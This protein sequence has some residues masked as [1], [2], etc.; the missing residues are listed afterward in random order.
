MANYDDVIEKNKR[1][2]T[3]AQVNA[4]VAASKEYNI[5]N[6]GN[7][8]G[9]LA[10]AREQYDTGYRGLQNMGLAGGVSAAPTSGEVPRLKTQ[11]QVP[12]EDYNRR[13]REVE[14]MR[15]NAL[16]GQMAESTRRARAAEAA[17]QEALR[18]AQLSAAAAKAMEERRISAGLRQTDME[19]TGRSG[20]TINSNPKRQRNVNMT[21][22]GTNGEREAEAAA[23]V[24]AAAE[25]TRVGAGLHQTA[26]EATGLSGSSLNIG[27]NRQ[28]NVNMTDTASNGEREA[29]SAARSRAAVEAAAETLGIATNKYN[30][31]YTRAQMEANAGKASEVPKF[32]VQSGSTIASDLKRAQNVGM[33][34]TASN[35]NNTGSSRRYATQGTTWSS[36]GG[37]VEGPSLKEVDDAIA[38]YE[39]AVKAYEDTAG[40]GAPSEASREP[41]NKANE[42]LNSLGFA[43]IYSAKRYRDSITNTN[44]PERSTEEPD[45]LVK[46]RREMEDAQAKY[47]SALAGTNTLQQQ[48]LGILRKR[49]DGK[50]VTEQDVQNV[51]RSAHAAYISGSEDEKKAVIDTVMEAYG[52]RP[53][54]MMTTHINATYRS[55]VTSSRR[56]SFYKTKM[57]P[58]ASRALFSRCKGTASRKNR[59]PS[60]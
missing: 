58:A 49:S 40:H 33:T 35:R 10:S 53:Y 7:R 43:S 20:S 19:A 11:L 44:E 6:A 51:M 29:E 26:R 50:Q 60:G 18:Q 57:L 27:Q 47:E 56:C 14:N 4:L 22:T 46:A 3:K 15:L 38:V 32:K 25:A 23:R 52:F 12:F 45:Y 39:S 24:R 2:L 1:Y 59:R 16:G 5:Q 8:A 42:L 9:A 17:R 28:R 30:D 21:D 37:Q 36:Q 41:I 54:G 13:I 31:A 34:D 55:I 48:I